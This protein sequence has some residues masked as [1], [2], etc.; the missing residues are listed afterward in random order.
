MKVKDEVE[1]CGPLSKEH[2]Y[3]GHF[4]KSENLQKGHNNNEMY[5]PVVKENI[6]KGDLGVANR[7]SSLRLDKQVLGGQYGLRSEVD[8]IRERKALDEATRKRK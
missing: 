2:G 6:L 1:T 3:L 5:S 4:K 8:S 7:I